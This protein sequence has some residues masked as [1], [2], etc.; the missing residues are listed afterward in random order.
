MSYLPHASSGSR[1]RSSSGASGV[2]TGGY[3]THPYDNNASKQAILEA[4]NNA[5]TREIDTLRT[6][7][8]QQKDRYE[9]LLT[10]M[11][12]KN[13][14]VMDEATN[15][16]EH[17]ESETQVL[18]QENAQLHNYIRELE[19]QISGGKQALGT[20]ESHTNHQSL[21]Q[22]QLLSEVEELRHQL[23][24]AEK[25]LLQVRKHLV[26]VEEREEDLRCDFQDAQGKL[27][28]ADRHIKLLSDEVAESKMQLL[29]NEN[30][31]E[32]VR[33][34][35]AGTAALQ[36]EVHERL[37]RAVFALAEEMEEVLTDCDELSLKTRLA[38]KEAS[39][40]TSVAGSPM[41]SPTTV[42]EVAFLQQKL[43]AVAARKSSIKM[44]KSGGG[45]RSG[46]P[47]APPPPPRCL[48]QDI[49]SAADLIGA[50]PAALLKTTVNIMDVLALARDD[51]A[52]TL[53][54]VDEEGVVRSRSTIAKHVQSFRQAV[55]EER[56]N[57]SLAVRQLHD[58]EDRIRKLTLE[59]DE[60]K[61]GMA[62]VD[63][64]MKE[65]D[66][67]SEEQ[68]KR[69][70][71]II[72][73]RDNLRRSLDRLQGDAGSQQK[74]ISELERRIE[75]LKEELQT[76]KWL[77][78]QKQE[79]ASAA[80]IEVNRVRELLRDNQ[81]EIQSLN[82]SLRDAK[83]ENEERLRW[84]SKH[85]ETANDLKTK[86]HTT[87]AQLSQKSREIQH[88][89]ERLHDLEGQLTSQRWQLESALRSSSAA[90]LGGTS[91]VAMLG[92]SVARN[93]SQPP[94]SH[95]STHN[96]VSPGKN[97]QTNKVTEWTSRLDD[98]FQRAQTAR[99]S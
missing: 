2:G 6:A 87:T 61:L 28:R 62:K 70:E 86:L 64:M 14:Q 46:E 26:D 4:D 22:R 59:N 63:S 44:I 78:N 43:E 97:S 9:Q 56:E 37:G 17:A 30:E 72:N 40:D 83:R 47:A 73:E 35:K 10:D 49:Y 41:R 77:A 7:N 94:D 76:T 68:A 79:D 18:R 67:L 29:R 45:F 36:D 34:Q 51:I 93:E 15:R 96:S 65:A 27:E 66:T 50:P 69:L 74:N 80:H 81:S 71:S 33:M 8:R 16:V 38:L 25:E 58:A 48:P 85:L 89:E 60:I 31:L 19:G 53:R 55:D 3:Y 52:V 12:K 90:T 11:V 88:L 42:E 13:K 75:E 54:A 57:A 91:A 82:A 24:V 5:R 99:K 1:G 84:D 23:Q 21:M 98:L 20:L 32:D 95:F 39:A 92:S